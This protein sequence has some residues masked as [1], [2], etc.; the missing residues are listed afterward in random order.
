MLETEMEATMIDGNLL[1]WLELCALTVLVGA[2]IG[3]STARGR[4]QA[5]A[6]GGN[7]QRV[8]PGGA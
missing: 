3:A 7:E 8:R 2:G 6:A 1:F 5:Q 4:R